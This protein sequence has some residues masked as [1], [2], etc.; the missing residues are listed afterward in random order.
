MLIKVHLL[1]GYSEP[2]TYAVPKEWDTTT[3]VGS[4][5]RVPFRTYE[6]PVK[7]SAP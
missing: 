4:I 1:K 6:A 7:I 3:L 2:L 5:V